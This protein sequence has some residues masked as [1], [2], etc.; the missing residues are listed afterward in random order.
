MDKLTNTSIVE[1]VVTKK[2]AILKAVSMLPPPP[3]EDK[4]AT[5]QTLCQ[6]NENTQK[7]NSERCLNEPEQ[8]TEQLQND[9]MNETKTKSEQESWR[10]ITDPK[11]RE[12][13]YK[14]AHYEANKEKVKLRV[15]SHYAAN[16]DTKK[17]N[18]II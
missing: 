1:K 16:K 5:K 17:L 10:T 4:F 7:T 12:K 18:I 11:L 2:V 13:M 14:K 15:R 9:T 3:F 8:K 6:T